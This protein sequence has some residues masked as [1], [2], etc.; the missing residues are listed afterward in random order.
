MNSSHSLKE[1]RQ[2]IRSIKEK[3][4]QKFNISIIESDFQ[5]LWQKSQ[6]AISMIANTKR[7]LES[8]LDQIEAFIFDNYPVQIISVNKEFI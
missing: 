7:L 8:S 5:N 6:L 4:K 3:L 2:I 1:K